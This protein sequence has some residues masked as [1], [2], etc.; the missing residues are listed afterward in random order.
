MLAALLR[1]FWVWTELPE[2]R[3]GTT[4]LRAISV[5]SVEYPGIGGLCDECIRKI[6]GDLSDEEMNMFL[7]GMAIDSEAE[8]I[9]DACIREGT[10]EFLCRVVKAGIGFPQVDTRW[11]LAEILRREVPDRDKLLGLLSADP[12]PYVRKRAENV[13]EYLLWDA[14]W[15]PGMELK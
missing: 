14:N 15:Q 13:K 3:W 10:D 7:M 11:Q 1:D 6:N 2:D 4:D 12:H 8:A 9:L 5:D